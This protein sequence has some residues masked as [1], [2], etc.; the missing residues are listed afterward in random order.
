[1]F[2][3]CPTSVCSFVCCYQTCKNDILKTNES[4]FTTLTKNFLLYRTVACR[5][6]LPNDNVSM[7]VG[8]FD[9]VLTVYSSMEHV[10]WKSPGPMCGWVGRILRSDSCMSG[11]SWFKVPLLSIWSVAV[12]LCR[13][14]CL[15]PVNDM[16]LFHGMVCDGWLVSYTALPCPGGSGL[17]TSC[18]TVHFFLVLFNSQTKLPARLPN[19]WARAVLVR[20]TVD[21]FGLLFVVIR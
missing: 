7:S 13:P 20:H 1:M 12:P 21:Q 4:I 16:V 2:S 18:E 3:T 17:C 19:V 6:G 15:V 9:H 14:L 11:S 10:T 8:H 5:S